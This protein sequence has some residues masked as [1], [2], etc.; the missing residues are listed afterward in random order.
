[1]PSTNITASCVSTPTFL[2]ASQLALMDQQQQQRERVS[3]AWCNRRWRRQVACS[4]MRR[5]KSS[6]C[7]AVLCA[8]AMQQQQPSQQ[9][10]QQRQQQTQARSSQSMQPQVLG[11]VRTWCVPYIARTLWLGP[12][13]ASHARSGHCPVSVGSLPCHLT[14]QELLIARERAREHPAA[15]EDN[16]AAHASVVRVPALKPLTSSRCCHECRARP[17]LDQGLALLMPNSSLFL[18]HLL[19]RISLKPGARQRGG[20]GG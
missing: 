15:Q 1:M 6:N 7:Q 9:Q 13:I 4:G 20:R 10:H 17:L 2:R 12:H 11:T 19:G 3:A 8:R 16:T 5:L 18:P 14:C